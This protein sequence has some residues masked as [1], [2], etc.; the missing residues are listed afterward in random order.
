MNTTLAHFFVAA[1]Q[2]ANALTPATAAENTEL[3]LAIARVAI[4]S[5][6]SEMLEPT[7]SRGNLNLAVEALRR[8][9]RLR[10]YEPSFSRD[11]A[12]LLMFLGDAQQ[13]SRVLER[14]L[15]RQEEQGTSRLLAEA[16]HAAGEL[17]RAVSIWESLGTNEDLT[18]A[19]IASL[20]RGQHAEVERLLA[21]AGNSPRTRLVMARLHLE[22]GEHDQARSILESLVMQSSATDPQLQ[23]A[24]RVLLAGIPVGSG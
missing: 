21:R 7:Q 13:A 20:E 18:A 2:P 8:R 16:L 6:E 15:S 12:R 19:A 4:S 14:A 24:A 10:P 22:R 3:L 23:Q 9:V 5:V 17:S 11:L 1:N